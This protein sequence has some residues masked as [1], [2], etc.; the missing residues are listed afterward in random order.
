[1]A[2]MTIPAHDEITD[3]VTGKPVT[4]EGAVAETVKVSINGKT[5]N[6]DMTPETLAAFSAFVTDPSDE[7]R[8]AFGALI[9]RPRVGT[10][11]SGNAASGSD[12]KREW[13]R[14]NG[15]PNLGDRGKFTEE[16]N[17]RW[18]R[19]QAENANA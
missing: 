5:S 6:L 19:H 4:G 1:M 17:D 10:S 14:A 16:M 8:R 13:L 2:R 11:R 15:Y 7:T 3:D 18:A 9:P 12:G